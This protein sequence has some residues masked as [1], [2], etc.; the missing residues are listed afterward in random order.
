MSRRPV[1]AVPQCTVCRHRKRFAVEAAIRAGTSL[2]AIRKSYGL[3]PQA[4]MRHRD[5]HLPPPVVRQST[6]GVLYAALAPPPADAPVAPRGAG[7]K[8]HR[9]MWVTTSPRPP[10]GTRC[11]K[12][13]GQ[14]WWEAL[15]REMGGC[16]KCWYPVFDGRKSHFS[17]S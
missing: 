10:A 2:R 3:S 13:G 1:I 4:L 16:V 12:C 7:D 5:K 11:E 14:H 15:N 17:S 6:A 9:W 8:R